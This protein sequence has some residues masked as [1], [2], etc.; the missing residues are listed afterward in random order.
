[1][2]ETIQKLDKSSGTPF[3]SRGRDS[4]AVQAKLVVNQPSDQHEAEADSAAERVVNG[5][6]P[7][8][9]SASSNP[10]SVQLKPIAQTLTPRIQR[11]EAPGQMGQLDIEGTE[12]QM[13]I[14]EHEGVIQQKEEDQLMGNDVLAPEAGKD[15][16]P[17]GDQLQETKGQGNPLPSEVKTE[18]ESGFGADFSQVKTHTGT[19][20]ADMNQ[21]LKAKAFTNQGDIYFNEGNFD[22]NSKDGKQ[23]LAHE[24][25]HTIQQ[26]AASPN[27]NQTQNA[28]SEKKEINSTE[29][30]EAKKQAKNNPETEQKVANLATEAVNKAKEQKPVSTNQNTTTG[31]EQIAEKQPLDSKTK[32][33]EASKEQEN[34]KAES[35]AGEEKEATPETPEG[36]ENVETLDKA[37]EKEV[38]E[39]TKEKEKTAPAAKEKAEEGDDKKTGEE[40]SKKEEDP[41]PE[42]VKEDYDNPPPVKDVKVEEATDKVGE[43]VGVDEEANVN[44]EG[45]IMTAQQFRDQGK[46]SVKR[47]KTQTELREQAEKKMHEIEKKIEG[48]DKSLKTAEKNTQYR[49]KQLPKMMDKAIATS[50]QREAKV[51]GE[52]GGFTAEYNKNKGTADKLK[53][54]SSGLNEGSKENSNPDE[55]ESGE[56]SS[57]YE[58]M[59]SGTATMAEGVSGTG[60]TAAKLKADAKISKTKNAKTEKDYNESKANIKKSKEKISSEKNRNTEAKSKSRSLKP[61]FQ[62]SK[63][64][65]E[66]LT[67]EGMG[68]MKTSFEMENETHRA[69]YF[70]Y[71]DMKTIDG[72][73][74]MIMQ[75]ELRAQSEMSNGPEA[76]LFRYSNLKSDG[77][78][79]A[80]VASLSEQDRNQLGMQLMQFNMNFEAWIENKKLEFGERVEQKR[81]EKIDQYNG[82]R[83]KGLESPLNKATKNIDK[84]SKTG[85]LWT[86]MTKALESMW[87]GL[88]NITWADVSKIG[89]A[90]IN[91]LETYRTIADAIGGIWTD[92]SDWKGFSE[93]PVGMILQKGS[94]VGVKLLTIAGVITGLLGVLSALTSVAA[95]FFP[96]LIPV[97]AWLIGATGTMFTVTFWLG[98]ITTALSVMSGIKNIY[99]VHTAKTAEEI[100]QGNHKLKTDAA[101]T[102]AGVIAM[103]G[104]KSPPTPFDPTKIGKFKNT[105]VK[106]FKASGGFVKRGV[107]KIPKLVSKAFKKETWTNLYASFKKFSSKKVDNLFGGNKKNIANKTDNLSDVAPKKVLKNVD[108][109]KVPSQSTG[110]TSKFEKKMPE[111]QKPV[112]VD[113]K[114]P[115]T[116]KADIPT[117]K[118]APEMKK[119]DLSEANIKKLEKD[120][121]PH[122]TNIDE[123]NAP[124]DKQVANGEKPPKSEILN[125]DPNIKDKD[126]DNLK[127]YEDEVDPSTKKKMEEDADTDVKKGKDH[128]SKAKALMM[129]RVIA[130]SND[131]IDTPVAVLKAELAPLKAMKG[132]DDFIIEGGTNGVFQIYMIGSKYPVKTYT[133]AERQKKNDLDKRKKRTEEVPLGD[134]KTIRGFSNAGEYVERSG[135]LRNQLHGINGLED[136]NVGIRGSS[137]TGTSTKTGGP[138]R[139]GITDGKPSDLDF[140]FTSDA[141]EKQLLKAGLNLDEPI[142]PAMLKNVDNQL[143]NT[144][145]NFATQTRQQVGRESQAYFLSK[146][147]LNNLSSKDFL[148]R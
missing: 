43:G 37:V 115:T 29:V 133:I 109:P 46:E 113:S 111:K 14:V 135:N 10:A 97:A 21:S 54:E 1:M 118:N 2:K 27:K 55:K 127:K 94:S 65:E 125:D 17:L 68:L 28:N 42:G 73:D 38:S 96:P 103:V 19:K 100:Y 74:E 34:S 105:V 57:N 50:K 116:A 6:S 58:E 67:T 138:F 15:A 143:Y 122:K 44:V 4:L 32:E 91:P 84:I 16:T 104:A 40:K 81:G 145:E 102:T 30:A 13:G 108:E 148:I 80:F 144:L 137:V 110:T 140:F 114:T 75:E 51:S 128:D 98:L 120:I 63:K 59:E 33:I 22:P 48:S 86:S 45:L 11:K 69:Q 64:Q 83:N 141:F 26:G 130:E 31:N 88:K 101:N 60:T 76:L 72:A 66:Q 121:D 41:G 112:N 129:A 136:A 70:Y 9:T 53:K 117:T 78:R 61:K 82:K 147:I 36:Q 134:D 95:F 119:A 77:E 8:G 52:V 87:E 24:L 99:N 3:R 123:V 49:E 107:R 85:L 18:M 90:M 92:L 25:T 93:D 12:D 131:K 39:K 56:L 62:A 132:V 47:A 79:E 71:K 5:S 35:K 126:L 146:K 106:T 23:L 7:T 142:S 89:L 124:K 139:T 20:A